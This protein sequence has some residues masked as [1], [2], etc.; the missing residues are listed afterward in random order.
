MMPRTRHRTILQ[1]A[2]IIRHLA[3]FSEQLSVAEFADHGIA[4]AAEGDRANAAGGL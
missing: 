2:Q 4:G 3:E 1:S